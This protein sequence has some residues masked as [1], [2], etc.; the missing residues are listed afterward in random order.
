VALGA[1]AVVLGRRRI[2]PRLRARQQVERVFTALL[3][4]CSSIA[5]LTTVGI[6]LS[7][8]F[9]AIRFFQLVPFFDFLFGLEWS[10]QTAIRSDQVGAS[11]SFGAVPLFAGTFL[12]SA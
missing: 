11:G 7:V 4:S 9:E 5:I 1:G 6:V 8:L 3:A 12:I 2:G 10:P